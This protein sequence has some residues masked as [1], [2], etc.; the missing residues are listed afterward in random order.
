MHSSPARETIFARAATKTEIRKVNPF[1]YLIYFG[2]FSTLTEIIE[3]MRFPKKEK[4]AQFDP[5]ECEIIEL[6][7]FFRII[8]YFPTNFILTLSPN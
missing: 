4:L 5:G 2:R 6:C 8:G 3:K 7:V 1:Y